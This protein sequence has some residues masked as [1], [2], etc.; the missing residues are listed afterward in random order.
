MAAK[1]RSI[2]DIGDMVKDEQVTPEEEAALE[3]PKTSAQKLADI[4][5]PQSA[6]VQGAPEWAIIP[7]NLVIPRGVEVA[8]LRIPTRT[9]GEKVVILWDLSVRD[10]R[11]GRARAMND[12]ARFVEEMAKQMIRTIDD[13]IVSWANP[14]DVE[15]FWD[16]IGAKH[17]SVIIAWYMKTHQ[18]D[19]EERID[20]FANRVVAKRAV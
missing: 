2:D 3:G 15:K 14:L 8:F 9:M 13:K 18:L 17:R 5:N 16:E 4:A 6:V 11:F 1:K 12:G 7:P 20:F 19:D 10:E